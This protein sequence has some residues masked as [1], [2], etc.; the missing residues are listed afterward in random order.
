MERSVAASYA[1]A[2]YEVSRFKPDVVVGFSWGAALA[3]N[4]IKDK[5]WDGPTVLL[6]PAYGP[7]FMEQSKIPGYWDVNHGSP[8]QVDICGCH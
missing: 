5:D 6:A 2:K 1:I 3:L 4:L 8:E 7:L